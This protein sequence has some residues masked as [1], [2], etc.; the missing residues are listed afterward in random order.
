[1]RLVLLA[2]LLF[3]DAGW[4]PPAVTPPLQFVVVGFD[5]AGDAADLR[6]WLEVGA[7]VHAR[8]TF[9]LSGVYLLAGDRAQLYVPPRHR[10][11]ASDIGFAIAPAG[12]DVRSNIEDLVATLDRADAA[13]HE[14]ASHFNGHFCG[15]SAGAVGSWGPVDWQREIAAFAD[16]V[17]S[18]GPHND[19][20]GVEATFAPTGARTPCL[21]GMLP[22]ERQALAAAGYRYDASEPADRAPYRAEGVWEIPI[23]L[24][25][26]AG[27]GYR[28]LATDYNLYLNQSQA[29]DA[30]PLVLP[31]L[32]AQ[33]LATYRD[34][35]RSHYDG[36]REPVVFAHHF[37]D[38]N[39][40]IYSSV[41]EQVLAEVCGRSDVRCVTYRELVDAL[42]AVEH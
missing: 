21:E 7:S 20:P 14:I 31:E 25:D 10:A 3:G 4:L 17:A 33:A 30:D 40:G 35:F 37:E 39:G 32:R 26:V 9:F 1:M 27:A 13:G 16:L 29:E 11:G 28:T 38:W 42:D 24:L 5:G 2:L 12:T 15:R 18:V 23:P 34:Y 22:F 19:L 36:S 6:H 8:F 41:L